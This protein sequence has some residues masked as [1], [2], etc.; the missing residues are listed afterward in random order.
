MNIL[1]LYISIFA[2]VFSI[3][4][5]KLTINVT[6]IEILKGDIIIGVFDKEHNFLKDGSAIKTYSIRVEENT[7]TIVINDLP[8]GD[9]AISI[10]HDENS[11]NTCNMNFLGIPKEGYGFSNNFK[12][13]FSAPNYSDCKFM[14]SKDLKLTIKL[15]Y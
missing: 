14:L 4:N 11:D 2:S 3:E 7:E 6:N 5:P 9:Y 1:L 10:Y 12:P 15:I 8:T 13:K